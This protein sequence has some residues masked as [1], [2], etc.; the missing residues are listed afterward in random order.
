MTK[1]T[2]ILDQQAVLTVSSQ[3]EN[4]NL[5]ATTYKTVEFFAALFQFLERTVNKYQLL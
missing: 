3:K 4:I 2:V 5:E 1:P